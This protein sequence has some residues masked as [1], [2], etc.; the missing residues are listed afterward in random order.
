MLNELFQV[1][2][3]PAFRPAVPVTSFALLSM[4]YLTFLPS[5]A[6]SIEPEKLT[7]RIVPTMGMNDVTEGALL[8]KTNQHGRFLPAPIL[9]TDVQITVTG[10]VARAT[11]R[12]EFTNP[13]TSD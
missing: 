13:S 9:K 5:P 4:L 2:D 3:I 6:S 7:T 12:Q 10:I 1:Q 11:V 8:F